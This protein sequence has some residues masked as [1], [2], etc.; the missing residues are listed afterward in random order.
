M[1]FFRKEKFVGSALSFLEYL[2]TPLPTTRLMKK[3]TKN[4]TK[5]VAKTSMVYLRYKLVNIG[6]FMLTIRCNFYTPCAFDDLVSKAS[7]K[8]LPTIIKENTKM[9]I[10]TPGTIAK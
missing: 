2:I 10:H 9:I 1:E 3:L 7:R 8:P 4:A 5:K 6:W